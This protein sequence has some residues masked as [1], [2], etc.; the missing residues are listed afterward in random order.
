MPP[1][2]PTPSL[3]EFLPKYEAD[4]NVWWTL[5][6]GDHMNLFDEAVGALQEIASG[7]TRCA[8]GINGAVMI[9][10][11]ALGV[12]E[13]AVSSTTDAEASERYDQ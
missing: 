8:P 11:R 5:A 6:C 3:A 10:R 1:N 13:K 12:E 4:D 2:E 7:S 9:A